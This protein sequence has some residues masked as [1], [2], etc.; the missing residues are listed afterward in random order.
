[1]VWVLMYILVISRIYLPPLNQF[2]LAHQ[3]QI[4]FFPIEKV[5]GVLKIGVCILR[6]IVHLRRL[7]YLI[8]EEIHSVRVLFIFFLLCET[9]L[10]DFVLLK[11]DHRDLPVNT[12]N[13]GQNPQN[14]DDGL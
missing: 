2:R 9:F 14:S 8:L 4:P 13:I 7:F 5:G 11:L 6:R 12:N 3:I 10:L 1:M